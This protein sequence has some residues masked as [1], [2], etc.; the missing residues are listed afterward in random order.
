MS[1]FNMLFV[2]VAFRLIAKSALPSAGSLPDPFSLK[3]SR[4][5]GR[6]QIKRAG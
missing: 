1:F 6:S 3:D 2:L 5:V 4:P